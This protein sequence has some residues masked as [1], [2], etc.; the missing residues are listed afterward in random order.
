[1]LPGRAHCNSYASGDGED[2]HEAHV[3]LPEEFDFWRRLRLCFGGVC[4]G[5]PWPEAWA[6]NDDTT[7]LPENNWVC[8]FFGN[9]FPDFSSRGASTCCMWL[10][11]GALERL[12]GTGLVWMH[13]WNK[14]DTWSL[15]DLWFSASLDV[16]GNWEGGNKIPPGWDFLWLCKGK[17]TDVSNVSLGKKPWDSN[18]SQGLSACVLPSW[19][20]HLCHKSRAD[21]QSW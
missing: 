6:G 10:F 3:W 11:P 15:Q 1:M 19:T 20:A 16:I 5:P 12:A 13:K 18:V 8:M 14:I 7:Q 4:L 2:S 21:S 9:S 17:D